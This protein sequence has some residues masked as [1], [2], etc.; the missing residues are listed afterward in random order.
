MGEP[1]ANVSVQEPDAAQI[2]ALLQRDPNWQDEIITN[3]T[4]M[5]TELQAR[6]RELEA[7]DVRRRTWVALE[8]HAEVIL[9]KATRINAVAADV[10][11]AASVVARLEELGI[12]APVP[13]ERARAALQR[14]MEAQSVHDRALDFYQRA[15]PRRAPATR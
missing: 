1:I 14:F 15:L 8:Q 12:H 4:Q 13:T 10:E 7:E 11:Q 6:V 2:L 9:A 5:H 3:L